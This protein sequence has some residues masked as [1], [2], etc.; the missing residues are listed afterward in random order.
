[1]YNSS[2]KHAVTVFLEKPKPFE[3]LIVFVKKL[4]VNEKVVNIIPINSDSTP[5]IHLQK[6]EP[7]SENLEL[8]FVESMIEMWKV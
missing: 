1:M 5:L 2:S 6:H 7:D 4:S 3:V 8:S